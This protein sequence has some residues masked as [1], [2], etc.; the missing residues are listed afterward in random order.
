MFMH[1]SSIIKAVVLM[2]FVVTIKWL[3]IYSWRS[4]KKRKEQFPAK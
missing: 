2:F 4:Y 1:K 3:K